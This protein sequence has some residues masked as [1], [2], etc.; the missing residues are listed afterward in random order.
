MEGRE[1]RN[2]PPSGL[3][4][5]VPEHVLMRSLGDEMVMLNLD[6]ESYFGLNEVGARLMQLAETGAT[7]A[8]ISE[9]LF[10]EFEVAREQLDHDVRTIAA[11]LIAAG[12]L[13]EA[14]AA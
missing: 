6:A 10:G 5:R 11:D 14:P 4:V 7:L 2:L 12:L 13:M 1:S 3:R 9:Q 8:E